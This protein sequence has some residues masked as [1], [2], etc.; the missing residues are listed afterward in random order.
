METGQKT[1]EFALQR[2]CAFYF[3]YTSTEMK[4]VNRRDITRIDHFK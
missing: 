3:D 2:I 1:R 4:K